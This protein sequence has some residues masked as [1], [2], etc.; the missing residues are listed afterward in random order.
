MHR[1]Y[2]TISAKLDRMI[3]AGESF[4]RLELVIKAAAGLNDDQRSALWLYAFFTSNPRLREHV[5]EYLT[6]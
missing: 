2:G 1:A 6:D 4:E 3:E 5:R